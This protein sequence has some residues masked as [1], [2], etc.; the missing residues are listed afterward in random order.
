MWEISLCID[1]SS[2]STNTACGNI[3]HDPKYRYTHK[4]NIETSPAVT[5]RNVS[6]VTWGIWKLTLAPLL[7]GRPGFPGGPG[8]P[9]EKIVKSVL[10]C[11]LIHN[12]NNFSHQYSYFWQSY[13][14]KPPINVVFTLHSNNASIKHWQLCLVD[15]MWH[16]FQLKKFHLIEMRINPSRGY[17]LEWQEIVEKTRN[18]SIFPVPLNAPCRPFYDLCSFIFLLIKEEKEKWG[19]TAFMVILDDKSTP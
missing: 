10:Y 2:K 12:T 17:E 9:W 16:A 11:I 13:L 8:S 19:K 3:N 14:S 5:I 7:P 18:N 15:K 4:W 6:D 1:S